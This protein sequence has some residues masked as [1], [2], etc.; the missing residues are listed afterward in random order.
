[1]R[2][3]KFR[4]WDKTEKKMIYT[5]IGFS[6]TQRG[7]WLVLFGQIP[8]GSMSVASS[9]YPRD[10]FEIMQYTGL[11]DKQEEEIYEGDILLSKYLERQMDEYVIRTC[12]VCFED[13]YYKCVGLENKYW[14]PELISIISS[15]LESPSQKWTVEVI[16]NIYENPDLLEK[17]K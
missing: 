14:K 6:G 10:N 2:E 15:L 7:D 8:E 17:V 5:P 12:K 16:G 13:G 3:I 9:I 11:K 1:M 4:V